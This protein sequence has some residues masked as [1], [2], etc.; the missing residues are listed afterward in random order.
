MNNNLDE[1]PNLNDDSLVCYC[2]GYSKSDI[3][4]DL[5]KNGNSLIIER[6]MYEKKLGGCQCPSTNPSGR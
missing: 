4:K 5:I 1:T 2:F 6:I 3:E